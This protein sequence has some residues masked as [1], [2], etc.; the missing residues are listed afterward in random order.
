MNSPT[1]GRERERDGGR[2]DK[3]SNPNSNTPNIQHFADVYMVF[4]YME[5]DLSALLR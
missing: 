3:D 4:D 1:G 2:R 5:H